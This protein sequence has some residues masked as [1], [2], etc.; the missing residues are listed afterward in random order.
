MS[1][2]KETVLHTGKLA[3][4]DL[5][6][7]FEGQDYDEKLEVFADQMSKIVAY[8]DILESADCSGVEPLYSPMHLTAPP[9][10]DEVK[11]EY[12]R[13]QELENAPE[14]GDGFFLVPRVI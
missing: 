8:M 7:L 13:E 9:R 5:R 2:S 14:Q 12:S 10:A 6:S 11:Q 3:R 4:L 1:V